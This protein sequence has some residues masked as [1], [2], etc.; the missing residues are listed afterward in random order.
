MGKTA[1]YLLIESILLAYPAFRAEKEK[2]C[3][4]A[5]NLDKIELGH[6]DMVVLNLL[7]NPAY[8]GTDTRGRQHQSLG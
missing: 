1:E 7:S 3:G 2:I 5:K 8:M 6:M 4:I